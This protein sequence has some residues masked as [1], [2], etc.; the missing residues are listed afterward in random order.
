MKNHNTYAGHHALAVESIYEGR[1]SGVSQC[2]TKTLESLRSLAKWNRNALLTRNTRL[3]CQEHGLQ[4]VH[5]AFPGQTG[6]VARLACGCERPVSLIS[7][8]DYIALVNRAAK[9]KIVRKGVSGG[10]AVVEDAPATQAA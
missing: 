5:D 10:V 3:Y 9:I 6:S 7:G 1:G 8:D 4:S 2:P